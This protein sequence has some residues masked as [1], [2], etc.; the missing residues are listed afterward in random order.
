[1][2]FNYISNINLIS[3]YYDSIL[4][5]KE[6]YFS[7][8]TSANRNFYNTVLQSN[9]VNAAQ[10]TINAINDIYKDATDKQTALEQDIG[11]IQIKKDELATYKILLENEVTSGTETE[12]ETETFDTMSPQIMNRDTVTLYNLQYLQIFCKVLGIVIIIAIFWKYFSSITGMT[13][14]PSIIP[15]ALPQALPQAAAAQAAA[16]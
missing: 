13:S 9:N 7:A 14:L 10:P 2:A 15:Q 3:R 5:I 11:M 8:L 1:M 16:T 12:T 6:E 4:T